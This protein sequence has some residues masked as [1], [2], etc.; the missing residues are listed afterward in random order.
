MEF[1]CKVC[2][3]DLV[4]QGKGLALCTS[5]DTLQTVSGLEDAERAHLLERA[6]NLRRRGRF[7]DAADAVER[8]LR[9]DIGDAEA[10][11]QS[12]LCRFGV[13]FEA[14]GNG[15][16]HITCQRMRQGSVLTDADYQRALKLASPSAAELYTR[17]ARLIAAMQQE[18]ESLMAQLN[19]FDV[20]IVCEPS[21]ASLRA[22]GALHDALTQQQLNVYLANRTAAQHPAAAPEALSYVAV[23][24]AW[25]MVV[26]VSSPEEAASAALMNQWATYQSLDSRTRPRNLIVAYQGMDLYDLPDALAS[27]DA[28]QS[29]EG[30]GALLD[31]AH[32]V[33]LYRP[34]RKVQSAPQ[35]EVYLRQAYEYLQKGEFN[36]AGDY[37]QS[38]LGV[39]KNHYPARVCMFLAD[40]EIACADESGLLQLPMPLMHYTDLS[41]LLLE[42][43]PKLPIAARLRELE[44]QLN[45]RLYQQIASA[46]ASGGLSEETLTELLELTRA[47]GSYKDARTTLAPRLTQLIDQERSRQA[48]AQRIA[49]L[50][51]LYNEAAS[52]EAAAAK[53][54]YPPYELEKAR[55]IFAALNGFSDSAQRIAAIDQKIADFKAERKRKEQAEK[56][57]KAACLPLGL[58]GCLGMLAL[59]VFG[60][61]LTTHESSPLVDLVNWITDV[62]P[63]G[64]LATPLLLLLTA[65]VAG[66]FGGVMETATTDTATATFCFLQ[67][68]GQLV[69]Q[70]MFY[71]QRSIEVYDLVPPGMLLTIV[72]V[73]VTALVSFFIYNF[74]A[75]ITA[76]K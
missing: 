51:Q 37:A 36:L 23:H 38:A 9:S 53:S 65:F 16:Y 61:V 50:Q 64:A 18:C 52:Y 40:E 66:L 17:D 11:W 20:A 12:V 15:Q 8:L 3:G 42:I 22:A 48:E 43:P 58:A 29:L 34:A 39:N 10:Y 2:G 14:V 70:I 47:L 24:T 7:T 33:T 4:R 27:L 6:A 45:E 32:G 74:G 71:A 21:E 13:S 63:I 25:A 54:S 5:C 35:H 68:L 67:V 57:R 60:C 46:T 1:T 75:V 72:A 55:D 69:F 56:A 41:K 31:L 73:A 44:Q 76:R 28:V 30:H 19:P 49:E 59:V 62:L 26:I